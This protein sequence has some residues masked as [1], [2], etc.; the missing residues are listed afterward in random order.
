MNYNK[1]K[2]AGMKVGVYW[3]SYATAA[4]EAYL[5]ADACLHCLGGRQLDMP[6]F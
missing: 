2:A 5:E 3:F 4:D 6:I 1:A